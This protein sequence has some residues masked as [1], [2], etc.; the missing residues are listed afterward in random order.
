M[1]PGTIIAGKFMAERILVIG[2]VAAGMSAASRARRLAPEARIT[3]LE[4]GPAVAYGACGLPAFLAGALPLSALRAHPPEEFTDRRK[5]EVLTG[6][7]ALEIIPSRRQVLVR[8]DGRQTT[9][10]FDKLVIATGAE[11]ALAIPGAD[12]RLLFRAYTWEQ[13]ERLDRFCREQRP[14]AAAVI[15]GGYIGLEV[16]EALAQRGL[17]VRLFERGARLLPHFGEEMAGLVAQAAQRHIAVELGVAVRRVRAPRAEGVRLETTAGDC[18]VDFAVDCA[19]LRPS[20]GLAAAAG[21][22]LGSTGALAVDERQQTNLPA[23]WAAGDCAQTRD[24]VSGRAAWI[25]LGP[26]ANKQGRVAGQNAAGGSPARF[27]GVLG[28][29]AIRIFGLEAGRTG[30][31][32]EQARTAGFQPRAELV[33]AEAQPGYAGHRRLMLALIYDGPS[34]R[35]LGCEIVG[36]SGA[37]MP[38]LNAAAAALAGNLSLDALELLDLAYH[39]D[40]APLYDPLLIAAHRAAEPR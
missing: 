3:V 10:A 32:L 19:G 4:R 29:L 36:E 9:L 21:V 14:R 37:V 13:A 35:P 27:P 15:G 6:H 1:S 30:L 17:A 11:S 28:S 12:H 31:S 22:A 38:R 39:P 26:A 5:L 2:G 7:E 24:L 8:S 23:V 34:R 25:P 20:I 18:D 33:R 16:A 40:L